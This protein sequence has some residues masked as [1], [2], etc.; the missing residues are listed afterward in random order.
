MPYHVARPDLCQ[1][2]DN[3]PVDL[4]ETQE[5]LDRRTR[6]ADRSRV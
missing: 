6:T 1:P 2:A 4:I 3:D 5:G